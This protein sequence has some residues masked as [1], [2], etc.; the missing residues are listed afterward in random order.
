M[1]K[2]WFKVIC[3]PEHKYINLIY[4]LML[5]DIETRPLKHNWATQVK[6]VLSSLG[7]YHVWLAQGVGN[8]QSFLLVL[9]KD[10]QIIL[11]KTFRVDSLNILGHCFI[12]IFLTLI[13]SFI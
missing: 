11:F 5:D 10:L 13:F 6:R 8:Y 9:N 1:I 7:F 12:E 4:K 3:S 2:Y